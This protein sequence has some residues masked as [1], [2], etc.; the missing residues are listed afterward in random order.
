MT[1]VVRLHVYHQSER[2]YLCLSART[3]L[4]NHSAARLRKHWVVICTPISLDRPQQSPVKTHISHH[5][6]FRSC[7]LCP[8][9]RH[10]IK[11]QI[12]L[13]PTSRI[14]KHCTLI[15]KESAI[16]LLVIRNTTSPRDH[17]FDQ[18]ELNM[19]IFNHAINSQCWWLIDSQS[20]AKW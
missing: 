17:K 1:C 19:I 16:L 8:Q 6:L 5:I 12:R 10:A 18:A 4:P 15:P 13:N 2:F 11:V 9:S 7:R 3:S 14:S 20:K